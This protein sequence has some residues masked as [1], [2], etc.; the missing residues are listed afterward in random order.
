MVRSADY[1]TLK[2]EIEMIEQ[3]LEDLTVVMNMGETGY[4]SF[5]KYLE[6]RLIDLLLLCESD[7]EAEGGPRR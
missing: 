6:D 5:K 4:S 2:E 7:R 3:Q 1:L